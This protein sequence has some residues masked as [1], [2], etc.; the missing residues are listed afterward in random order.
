MNNDND[1]QATVLQPLDVDKQISFYELS[2]M[3]YLFICFQAIFFIHFEIPEAYKCSMQKTQPDHLPVFL[4]HTW[5][6]HGSRQDFSYL[7]SKG[8][9]QIFFKI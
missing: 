7:G 8:A 5:H 4:F 3:L 6:I 2:L 9:S 1:S